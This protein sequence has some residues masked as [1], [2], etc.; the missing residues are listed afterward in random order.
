MPLRRREFLNLVAGG[1]ATG[2]LLS[3]PISQAAPGPKIKALAFDA[4]PIFDP[5]PVFALVEQL[6]PGKDA[7]L[8]NAWRALRRTAG[9]GDAAGGV[10]CRAWPLPQINHS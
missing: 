5:R 6:F 1:V 2:V 8:S 9:M 10:T 7:D 4:L 3:T